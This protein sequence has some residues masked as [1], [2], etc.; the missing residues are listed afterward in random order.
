MPDNIAII[1]A[2]LCATVFTFLF[3]LEK[4][5]GQVERLAG[6]RFK[7]LIQ[8]ATDRPYKAVLVG[9]FTT[10]I[11]S[12]STAVSV[13]L[14]SLAQAGIIP[15]YNSLGVI[16]GANI[17]TTLTTQLVAF[18]VLN[19]APYILIIGFIVMHLKTPIQ[20]YG[21]AIFYFG[22]VFS[23][24]FIM[25]LITSQFSENAFILNIVTHTSNLFITILVGIFLSTILQSS[26]AG[27]A[28]V[29]ILASQGFLN[30]EQSLGIILGTNIG[31]TTTALLASLVADKSGK[32]VA[33][34]HLIFNVVGVIL[35]LP[36]VNPTVKFFTSI[37]VTLTQQVTF[38]HL[39]FNIF[40]AIVFLIGFKLFYRSIIFITKSR[41][42]EP[43]LNQN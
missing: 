18:K 35:F 16:I 38:S 19:I 42:T 28:V 30:F 10:S 41:S 22:L 4:F 2:S 37:N 8:K 39:F 29:V 1:I 24:L 20:R 25:S 34:G 21:K 23:S 15:L 3:S 40:T 7:E 32:Q 9:I 5:S 6:N 17:G 36:L 14:V 43:H 13:L 27:A 12:S 26:L 11:L 31:T 33:L